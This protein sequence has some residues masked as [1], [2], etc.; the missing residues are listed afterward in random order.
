MSKEAPPM[1]NV[2]SPAESGPVDSGTAFSA[3]PAVLSAE[4]QEAYYQTFLAHFVPV[5]PVELA[6]TRDLARQALAMKNWGLAGD[7]IRRQTARF[8]GDMGS[9]EGGSEASF[10]GLLAAAF[11]ADASYRAERYESLHTRGF[12][13]AL[14]QLELMQERRQA[15][16]SAP[17]P[18]NLFCA[19]SE[20]E[21]Y[22]ARRF[23]TERS[24]CEACGHDDG[25]V[26]AS[27][28][29]W[30]CGRC[31]RQVGYR[32]G[33]IMSNSQ[34]PLLI[35]F[36]SIAWVLWEPTITV[37]EL[38]AKTGLK[39]MGTVRKIAKRIRRALTQDDSTDRLAGLDQFFLRSSQLSQVSP[40][41]LWRPSPGNAPSGEPAT[42]PA[43][44]QRDVH[45]CA[46]RARG[47]R[48]LSQVS[49]T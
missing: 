19:E 41:A 15:V 20:C 13:R 35:W 27:R 26:I 5:G 40:S 9:S 24:C 42:F 48:A 43:E 45:S 39:R 47:Q 31:K 21:A 6:L 33:T 28:R 49:S 14:Q 3:A 34:I 23:A 8:V 12:Y 36:K 30:E 1:F 37:K 2:S 17:G 38:A 16:T 4:H 18:P 11:C 29:V 44:N 22:L 46:P 10:D 7:A 25:S 32:V